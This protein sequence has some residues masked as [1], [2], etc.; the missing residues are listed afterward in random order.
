MVEKKF[1]ERNFYFNFF[2][3]NKN[4]ADRI[5]PEARIQAVRDGNAGREKRKT[6]E[7]RE[8]RREGSP[9]QKE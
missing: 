9:L 8:Y 3:K 6:K 1:L 4:V 2:L 7:L 5:P